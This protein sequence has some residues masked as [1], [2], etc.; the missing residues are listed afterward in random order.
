MANTK[1]QQN[2]EKL[3]TVKNG[4]LVA[5]AATILFL[6]NHESAVDMVPTNSDGTSEGL[7]RRL[8]EAVAANK[9]LVMEKAA[10]EKQ[11]AALEKKLSDQLADF[12]KKYEA[13]ME[14]FEKQLDEMK[15]AQTERVDDMRRGYRDDLR[16]GYRRDPR[17]G[18]RDDM[19]RRGPRPGFYN[20]AMRSDYWYNVGGGSPRPVLIGGPQ[21]GSPYNYPWWDDRMYQGGYGYRPQYYGPQYGGYPQQYGYGPQHPYGGGRAVRFGIDS[22]GNFGVGYQGNRFGFRFGGRF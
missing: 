7:Q 8:A 22:R 12:D 13:Q 5:M 10:L 4:A 11:N 1:E 19:Y 15:R 9:T 18:Y 20:P 14:R 17:G 16:D 21:Y 3:F 2:R 6:I